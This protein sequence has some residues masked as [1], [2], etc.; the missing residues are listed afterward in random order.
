MKKILCCLCVCFGAV[1]CG[2]LENSVAITEVKQK[3]LEG[4]THQLSVVIDCRPSGQLSFGDECGG[5]KVCVKAVWSDAAGEELGLT[6]DCRILDDVGQ[7]TIVIES[8]MGVLVDAT[9]LKVSLSL[10]DDSDL[11][12]DDAE[13]QTQ[14]P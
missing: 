7:M 1:A 3:T 12:L 14:L 11:W 9:A 6:S 8:P 5:E 10:D 2:G 4:D 13:Y